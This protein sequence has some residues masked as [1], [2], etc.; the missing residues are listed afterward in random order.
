MKPL[1]KA[2]H[3]Q[4]QFSSAM[5]SLAIVIFK[6]KKKKCSGVSCMVEMYAFS[7][8]RLTR[9]W[10]VAVAELKEQLLLPLVPRWA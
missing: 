3:S 7:H 8:F 5:F 6:P 10:T 2:H 1:H 4:T 9:T